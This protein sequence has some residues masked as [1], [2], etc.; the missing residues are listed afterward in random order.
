MEIFPETVE[1][2]KFDNILYKRSSAIKG[3]EKM[4]F[5][6]LVSNLEELV[7]MHF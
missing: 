5:D 7:C 3:K 1:N 6:F 2:A 4:L